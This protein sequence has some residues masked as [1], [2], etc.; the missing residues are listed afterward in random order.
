M[1][2]QLI[3]GIWPLLAGYS[4]F[5]L[6]MAGAVAWAI[7]AP[8]FKKTALWVATAIAI[9]LGCY[10]TGVQHGEQRIK[11]QWDVALEREA[12]AGQEV[13]RDA[14]RDAERSTPDSVR[15]HRWNRDIRGAK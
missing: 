12:A 10:H 8:V 6:A 1:I 3:A 15:T 11:A 13:L 2:N 4:I 5:V 9:G 7:F 14:K